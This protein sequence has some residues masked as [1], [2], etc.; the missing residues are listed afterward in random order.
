[1]DDYDRARGAADGLV[2]IGLQSA[3]GEIEARG[4]IRLVFLELISSKWRNQWD[5]KLARSEELVEGT[6]TLGDAELHMY[7][8]AMRGS[9]FNGWTMVWKIYC[10]PSMWRKNCG[11]DRLLVQIHCRAARLRSMTGDTALGRSH[12]Y[13]A[14]EIAVELKDE[15]LLAMSLEIA[16]KLNFSSGVAPFTLVTEQNQR[17][18]QRRTGCGNVP[19]MVGRPYACP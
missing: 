8:G 14:F 13:M 7:R 16:A 9:G 1:M 3:D 4:L 17:F 12:A 5:E 6:R 10:M 18:M 15:W 19:G 2:K 11:A